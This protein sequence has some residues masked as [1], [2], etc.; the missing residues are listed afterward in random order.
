MKDMIG[1]ILETCAVERYTKV[2][3]IILSSNA[4][5]RHLRDNS[6]CMPYHAF[7]IPVKTVTR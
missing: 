1:S 3:L 7:A 5:D 4:H 2:P 6:P